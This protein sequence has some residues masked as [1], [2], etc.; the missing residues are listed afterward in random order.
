MAEQLPLNFE[1]RANQTFD[2]FFA[3]DNLELVQHLQ[4][5]VAGQGIA[6]IIIWGEAGLGKSHLLQA[7]CQQ[8][9]QQGLSAFYFAFAAEPLPDAALLSGLDSFDVVCFDNIEYISGDPEWEPAFISFL[10]QHRVPA[11][12]LILASHFAPEQLP[13]RSSALKKHLWACLILQ[14]QA[15]SADDRLQALMFKAHKMGFDITPTVA[16]FLLH[17]NDQQLASLW[18]LLAD[19]DRLSLAAKR[20]LTIP[21]L[22]T[23]L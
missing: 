17:H 14:L 9:Y 5:C 11:C 23:I 19:L 21:F 12:R 2:E 3:A 13:I 7:C 6:Q 15:L 10:N 18:L 22:K 4:H 16:Q 1:F 20:K 8:A